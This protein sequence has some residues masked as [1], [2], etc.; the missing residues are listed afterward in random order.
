MKMGSSDAYELKIH[1]L[2]LLRHVC[3]R[4]SGFLNMAPLTGIAFSINWLII[5][6]NQKT[7]SVETTKMT[8][9]LHAEQAWGSTINF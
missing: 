2:L 9:F 7:L 3:K 6:L 4:Q 5:K 1:F 8:T